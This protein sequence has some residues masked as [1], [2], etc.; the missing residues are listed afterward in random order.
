MPYVIP[1]SKRV[2]DSST[3]PPDI[4]LALS[5]KNSSSMTSSDP[6]ALPSIMASMASSSKA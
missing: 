6:N 2:Y 3:S 5:S 4:P 1:G